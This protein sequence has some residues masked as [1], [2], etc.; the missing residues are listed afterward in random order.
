MR[1]CRSQVIGLVTGGDTDLKATMGRR[2]RRRRSEVG[3][4]PWPNSADGP[5]FSDFYRRDD[6]LFPALV[7]L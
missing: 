7:S 3:S 6:Q 5:E 2:R 4:D 1:T